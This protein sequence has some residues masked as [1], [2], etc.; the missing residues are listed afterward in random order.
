MTKT[1]WIVG[2][3][4]L[5]AAALLSAC[6][7]GGDDVTAPAPGPLAEVPAS[8]SQSSTGLASYLTTLNAAPAADSDRAEPVDISN[9]NP[10]TSETAEPEPV[11]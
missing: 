10:P 11:S 5:V 3:Q 2:G 6:G 8:A 1:T 7:G 9:F 4:L